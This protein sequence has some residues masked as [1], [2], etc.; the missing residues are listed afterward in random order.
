MKIKTIQKMKHPQIMT[1]II[2]LIQMIIIK[3]DIG[4]KKDNVT[5]SDKNKED[6]EKK[7]LF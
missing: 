7:G 5:D 4:P 3:K 1:N 6:N 2:K